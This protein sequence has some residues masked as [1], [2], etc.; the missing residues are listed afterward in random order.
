[1]SSQNAVQNK[2]AAGKPFIIGIDGRSGSGKTV[3]AS[4]LAEALRADYEVTVFRLDDLYPGW[5]GLAEGVRIFSEEILPKLATGQPAT[6]QSWDWSAEHGVNGAPG[7]MRT[8]EPTEVIICEGV[9]V[10][11]RQARPY[12]DELI[13]LRAPLQT[14]YERAMSREGQVY[15][16]YWDE[17]A[18]Q[19]QAILDHDQI[20]DDADLVLV[21]DHPDERHH[22]SALALVRAKLDQ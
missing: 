11:V 13:W 1:M 10:G 3:L 9:C 17:W 4:R 22:T 6:W 8:T 12:L 16:S 21:A 7:Q 18:K 14:R 5:D 15:Y 2:P 20:Y 19:E